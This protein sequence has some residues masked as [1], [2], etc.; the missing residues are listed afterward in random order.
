MSNCLQNLSRTLA[1]TIGAAI[2]VLAPAV[3]TAQTAQV[4]AASSPA[5][6]AAWS[7]PHTPDGQPDLQ[8]YWTN[9]SFTPLERPA[10]YGTR[11]F[12]TDE[13]SAKLFKEGVIHSY[14]F[15]YD[16]PAGTPVYDAT[17][18]GLD[19]WQ[20]GVKPNKRTSLIIDPPNGRIPPLTPEAQKARA[21]R[22]TKTRVESPEDLTLGV[23]CLTFG[24]PPML[25]AAYN[26]NYYIVQMPGFIMIEAEWDSDARIIPL[27][28]RPHLSRDIHRWHGDSRGHWEGDTL[29]VE[30]TNFRP[31]ATYLNANPETLRI[32]EHFRRLDAYTIEYKFTIDDPST[33]TKPWSAII[34]MNRVEGP[35]FEYACSEGNND[36]INMLEAARA[37]EKANGQG[38]K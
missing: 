18:F 19:A 30:T 22:V 28:G 38:K 32:T 16:N 31:G 35:M 26:S 11:E 14:E 9:L 37:S 24:R 15:T 17:T 36:I 29:V 21:A 1:A 20:N 33:W 6:K 8:G 10:E 23:R 27:D 34:P 3:A 4:G 12:L 13:E 5:K 2:I 25:P 7:A